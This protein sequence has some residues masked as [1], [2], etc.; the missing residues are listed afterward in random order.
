MC[1]H[2]C[3][4][5]WMGIKPSVLCTLVKYSTT[6]LHPLLLVKHILSTYLMTL[7]VSISSKLEND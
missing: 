1:V 7:R 3:V 5:Q 6:E 2:V 4:R